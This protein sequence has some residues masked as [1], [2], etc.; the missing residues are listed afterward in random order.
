VEQPAPGNTSGLATARV[1]TLQVD[2]REWHQI[3]GCATFSIRGWLQS[4]GTAA[5]R[6]QCRHPHAPS[7]VFVPRTAPAESTRGACTVVA[8]KTQ[9]KQRRHSWS[10][11]NGEDNQSGTWSARKNAGPIMTHHA[12]FDPSL[13]KGKIKGELQSK[14]PAKPGK[15]QRDSTRR[16]VPASSSAT[17]LAT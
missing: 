13:F 7:R 8:L 4:A 17:N 5:H 11:K 3:L 12:C 14:S 2:P 16:R 6:E 15:F 1:T 9:M 10:A